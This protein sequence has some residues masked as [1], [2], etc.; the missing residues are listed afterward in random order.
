MRIKSP[1]IV[2]EMVRKTLSLIRLLSRRRKIQVVK[3]RKER[4]TSN[5]TTK[6]EIRNSKTPTQ[7]KKLNRRVKIHPHL[8]L[9]AM[10]QK[11]IWP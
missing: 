2:V 5:K 3:K 4:V 7:K 9:K 1:Q 6:M 8:L 11:L 10:M